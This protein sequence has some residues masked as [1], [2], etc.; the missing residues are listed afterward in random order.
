MRRLLLLL[1]LPAAACQ[2]L[3]HPFAGDVPPAALLSPRDSAGIYVVPV[4]GA[5]SP[6]AG[7]IA[8]AMAKAL[9]DADI[10]AST[11]G[12][13]KGSYELHGEARQE[14]LPGD[15]VE[16][17]VDWELLAADGRSLGH[18]PV[19]AEQPAGTSDTVAPAIAARAAPAI[20]R[21]V[22]DEPPTA[23]AHPDP[24]VSLRLV[25][26]APGD[27]GR[28]LTRAMEDALRRARVA[29]AAPGGDAPSFVLTGTVTMSPADSS[30]Q[31]RVRIGWALLRGDGSEIGQVS[32]ENAVPA[33]SLDGAWGD[34]AYAVATA[35]APG[36]VALIER[37]KAQA[38]GS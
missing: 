26:G 32:Q 27:G 8:E 11:R 28:S 31:Q 36:V 34:V 19:A 37:A 17:S 10:P 12:R 5:P 21:L 15:R 22:Q 16:I 30:K 38:I 35:A 14:T 3:P 29:L 20:R 24:A 25:T 6:I 4:A 23:A 7:D 1:A 18:A 33:G 9:R 2:P 13:N